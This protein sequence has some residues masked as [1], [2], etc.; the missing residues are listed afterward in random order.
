MSSFAAELWYRTAAANTTT[1]R[2]NYE[3]A[4]RVFNRD[5]RPYT[6]DAQDRAYN[7]WV[8]ARATENAASEAYLAA[9][10]AESEV[11]IELVTATE[12][13]AIQR[14]PLEIDAA[15][16]AQRV[17]AGE[18]A[19]VGERAWCPQKAC[20]YILFLAV[21]VTVVCLLAFGGIDTTKKSDSGGSDD[22][23][24]G[25]QISDG[26][27]PGTGDEF[28]A[29]GEYFQ[30]VHQIMEAAKPGGSA[31]TSDAAAECNSS[32][33][34]LRD[35]TQ[36]IA[37]MNR[38]VQDTV[39]AQ[40]EQVDNGRETLGNVLNGLMAAVSIAEALYSA[41]PAGPALSYHFQLATAGA[42]VTKDTDTT[43]GMH[44]AAQQNAARL[45]ELTC[46]YR[47]VFA[48]LSADG[49]QG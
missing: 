42:A 27:N 1:A 46:D 24:S 19:A 30:Y 49:V 14:V 31:W 6:W 11:E 25:S 47:E 45:R 9:I 2:R 37:D 40:A 26:K 17:A 4:L 5:E 41:G 33:A 36:R 34:W 44:T 22:E 38:D 18:E 28:S 35:A 20:V 13:G 10:D 7:E 8:N 32:T 21:I 39:Q 48:R 23:D 29:S 12:R 43:D 3:A 16:G 15:E